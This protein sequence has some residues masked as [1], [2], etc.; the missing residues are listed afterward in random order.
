[1]S[2]AFSRRDFSS[3]LL[4]GG[5]GMLLGF[6][7]SR[8]HADDQPPCPVTPRIVARLES[9][10]LEVELHLRNAR[11][12]PVLVPRGQI[13]MSGTLHAGGRSYS[14][15]SMSDTYSERAIYSRVGP[16]RAP[17]LSLS[18]DVEGHYA[19]FQGPVPDGLRGRGRGRVQLVARRAPALFGGPADAAPVHRLAELRV[20][21]HVRYAL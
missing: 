18:P 10:G 11:A 6:V 13:S 2:D 17:A 15:A 12:Q 5:A 8:A 21:G 4:T 16:A 19:T 1:M 20:Q 14:I 9:S 3:L 7:S